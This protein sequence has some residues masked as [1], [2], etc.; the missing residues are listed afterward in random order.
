[1]AMAQNIEAYDA[2]QPE[3]TSELQAAREQLAKALA[4]SQA[5]A[6]ASAI[7]PNSDLK[8][9]KSLEAQMD[10]AT[11]AEMARM[12][13]EKSRIAPSDD[14]PFDDTP[15][16][17]P[18]KNPTKKAP[19]KSAPSQVPSI[20]AGIDI[21]AAS[22]HADDEVIQLADQ[23]MPWLKVAQKTSPELDDMELFGGLKF[24]D[25]FMG[26]GEQWDGKLGLAFVPFFYGR[27]YVEWVSRDAGGGFVA[28]RGL[29]KGKELST[30]CTTAPNKKVATV[31]PNGNDLIETCYWAGFV[32]D[33]TGE[34]EPIQAIFALTS[35]FIPVSKKWNS[36]IMKYRLPGAANYIRFARPWKISTE[37]TS[38]E[39]G[40]WALP[41]V[42]PYKPDGHEG[43][44]NTF[45]LP[46]GV[47]LW[48]EC[49]ALATVFKSSF[50]LQSDIVDTPPIQDA[51]PF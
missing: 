18:V 2:G 48:Q 47:Q 42:A 34:S 49:D 19:V 15:P 9:K 12:E 25:F 10:A 50:T 8:K 26:T 36:M 1:M 14:L 38:N 7:D 41:K 17:P 5:H 29:I 27:T 35:T 33:P 46:N 30:Q 37:R 44:F 20:P 23:S 24:G 39:L 43:A 13:A 4:K 40:A 28:D 3:E 21:A 45:D 6:S 16:E 32:V 51:E 31:L 22:K 11:K